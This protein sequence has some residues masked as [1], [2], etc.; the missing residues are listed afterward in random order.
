MTVEILEDVRCREKDADTNFNEDTLEADDKSGVPFYKFSII[1]VGVTGWTAP[2]SIV[3]RLTVTG[4]SDSTGL[5]QKLSSCSGFDG[6]GGETGATWSNAQ[7][8]L[9]GT[10]GQ[11]QG[12][13]GSGDTVDF[14]LDITGFGNHCFGLTS[15]SS[16]AV[17]YGS[18]D[19]PADEA[20]QIIV[21]P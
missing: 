16:D 14:T 12:S 2:S 11:E 1:K 21:I 6:V 3:L 8:L 5:V 13:V 20:P 18:K 15:D 10:P 7:S 17:K 9:D 19:G 4:S